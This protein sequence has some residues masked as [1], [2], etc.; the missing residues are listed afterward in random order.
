MA[1]LLDFLP[2]DKNERAAV[3]QGL[4]GAG[5][6]MMQGA[7]N[8]GGSFA[9][10]FGA[11]GAQG[12][13][14]YQGALE[15]QQSRQMRQMQMDEIK[16]K[17]A[18]AERQRAILEQIGSQPIVDR[19]QLAQQLI[20]AG[21]VDEGVK[22]LTERPEK[23]PDWMNPEYEAHLKRVD[24]NKANLQPKK[25]WMNPEYEAYQKR[26]EKYKADLHQRGTQVGAQPKSK[27]STSDARSIDRSAKMSES[28]NSALGLLNQADL[29][30]GK[31]NS[32]RAEPILGK[33][34]RLAAAVG[35]GDPKRA[36]DYEIGEQIS[37][38]LGV[39]KLGLIGGSDTERELQVAIDTSPSPDK[40]VE[41]NK[42]I[43]ENSRRAIEILQAEPDFKSEWVEKNGS[44]LAKDIETGERYG[45]AWRKYQRENFTKE[46]PQNE[47]RTD[48]SKVVGY[49]AAKEARYQAWKAKQAR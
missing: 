11:G 44:L 48:E 15:G 28:S 12:M 38:D 4:L 5:F 3:L 35:I 9:P 34:S 42:K 47:P 40:T 8:P 37:K 18:E 33:A 23:Q 22:M 1:G 7:R 6:G 46:N 20:K 43:I 45:S 10:A 2:E 25:D 41:T 36:S 14:A 31:Y 30:Y 39:I 17:Q 32:S 13:Q 21:Q 26:I 27:I 24:E 49:D 29:L 16:R 19:A